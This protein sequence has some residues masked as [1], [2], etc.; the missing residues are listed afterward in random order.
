MVSV[1]MFLGK[2]VTRELGLSLHL[3]DEI[4]A[5]VIHFQSGLPSVND[6][7]FYSLELSLKLWIFIQPHLLFKLTVQLKTLNLETKNEK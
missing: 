1:A 3:T 5:S 4:R 2:T 6:A 7:K